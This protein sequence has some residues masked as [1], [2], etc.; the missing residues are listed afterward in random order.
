VAKIDLRFIFSFRFS[1]SFPILERWNHPG[2][3]TD[4][5]P[6]VAVR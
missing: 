4:H 6:V 3:V 1:S 2:Q 5:N